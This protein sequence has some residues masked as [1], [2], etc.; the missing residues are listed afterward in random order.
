MALPR[1][2]KCVGRDQQ[3]SW[4]VKLGEKGTGGWGTLWSEQQA[5]RSSAARKGDGVGH[6]AWGGWWQSGAAGWGMWEGQLISSTWRLLSNLKPLLRTE[7][8]SLGRKVVK[9]PSNKLEDWPERVKEFE[10]LV[11]SDEGTW[12]W[13]GKTCRLEGQ[14]DGTW[15]AGE[16]GDDCCPKALTK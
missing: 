4:N 9:D 8:I 3:S 11:S 7:N 5:A 2:Q 12:G 15:R 16:A 13:W 10:G 1:A 14:R 6:G